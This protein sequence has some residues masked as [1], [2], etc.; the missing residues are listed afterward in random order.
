VLPIAATGFFGRMDGYGFLQMIERKV[1]WVY[2][3]A[4]DL[5]AAV[6]Q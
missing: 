2:R 5:I 3:H 1:R 6:A 4:N